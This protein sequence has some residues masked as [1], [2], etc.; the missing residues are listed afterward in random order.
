MF[1]KIFTAYLALLLCVMTT[2]AAFAQDTPGTTKFPPALD[3]ADSLIR[4][5]NNART[6]LTTSITAGSTTLAVASTGSFP[7]SGVIQID[8]E[9]ILYTSKTAATFTGLTRGADST[10]AAS[11]ASGV[12]VRGVIAAIHTRVLG[13]AIRA[14]QAKQGTGASTPTSGAVMMG[15]GAGTSAWQINPTI[16]GV[17]NGNGSGLTGISIGSSTGHSA[18]GSITVT[19]DTDANDSGIIDVMTRNALRLRFQN[20]GSAL[21]TNPYTKFTSSAGQAVTQVNGAVSVWGEPA[22]PAKAGVVFES[23]DINAPVFNVFSKVTNGST[24]A[25]GLTAPYSALLGNYRVAIYGEGSSVGAEAGDATMYGGNFKGERGAGTTNN[26]HTLEVDTNNNNAAVAPGVAQALHGIS[27]ISGGIYN[28]ITAVN[29]DN[30]VAGNKWINA[31]HI[32][33]FS[34]MGLRID[35]GT[36]DIADAQEAAIA[37]ATKASKDGILGI[38]YTDSSPAGQFL[39]L[40]R[41]DGT[42]NL[43]FVDLEGDIVTRGVTQYWRDASPTKAGAIGSL[44]P[45]GSVTDDMVFSMFTGGTWTER[46][47]LT[48]AGVLTFP[49]SGVIVLGTAGIATGSAAPSAACGTGSIYL[50][51]SG[52]VGLYV[53]DNSVWVAK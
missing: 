27:I 4:A 34:H 28:G 8:S 44:V 20:D 18:I 11:H 17:F 41:K 14:G 51:T 29:I 36:T 47:R 3:S 35:W 30:T 37:L 1:R 38:R 31:V 40:Q 52:S 46:M 50:R 21:W 12:A 19:A 33:D 7:A 25:A 5:T 32:Q 13:D 26:V 15:T 45:G 43:F 16:T 39:R 22:Y 49:A 2:G 42:A 53:C 6:T 10:T 48:N 24:T 23:G 9:I